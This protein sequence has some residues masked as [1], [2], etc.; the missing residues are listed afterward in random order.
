M[1]VWN[2]TVLNATELKLSD[3]SSNDPFDDPTL[4]IGDEAIRDFLREQETE[5]LRAEVRRLQLLV[6]EQDH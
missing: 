2:K 6:D 3:S 1:R 5:R 4:E